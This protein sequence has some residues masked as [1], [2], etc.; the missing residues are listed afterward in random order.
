MSD[1]EEIKLNETAD[2]SKVA[3]SKVNSKNRESISLPKKEELVAAKKKEEKKVE[4]KAYSLWD[5]TKFTLPFLWKGGLLIRL[6]TILTFI[7]LFLSKGLN[8]T[9]PLILKYA[10]D[11]IQM[12]QDDK[13][14]P[15]RDQTYFL[16]AMYCAIRFTADFVNN[17]RE[18]P[19]ANVSASAEIYIAH[20]VYTH[21]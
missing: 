13:D 18:I 11:N 15:N 12:C 1:D 10:I 7:L 9:H 8:V 20:L 21:I 16:V 17:I 3:D 5:F 4:K 19:F 6:Q 14:C 2:K